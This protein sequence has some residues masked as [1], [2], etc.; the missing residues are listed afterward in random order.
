MSKLFHTHYWHYWN[1]QGLP[2]QYFEVPTN[3]L[4]CGY[5]W[6]TIL[7]TCS[8]YSYTTLLSH[9]HIEVTSC[10]HQNLTRHFKSQHW[11]NFACYCSTFFDTAWTFNKCIM[12]LIL[13]IKIL[14]RNGMILIK[15]NYKAWGMK[16]GGDSH[17][18]Y[19]NWV[20]PWMLLRIHFHFNAGVFS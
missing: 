1:V 15:F 16:G 6:W 7:C 9:N 10:L 4:V 18:L 11:L 2:W 14:L 5:P 17:T 12:K 8:Y 3:L 19:F 20:F 13:K